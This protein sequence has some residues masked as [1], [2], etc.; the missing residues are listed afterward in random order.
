MRESRLLT[1]PRSTTE[2]TWPTTHGDT[3]TDGTMTWTE[4]GSDVGT[5]VMD[6]TAILTCV[7]RDPVWSHYGHIVEEGQT[8]TTDDSSVVIDTFPLTDL[9]TTRITAKITA[10]LN[11]TPPDGATF[12][13][14]G[15][16]ARSGTQVTTVRYP[17]TESYGNANW[18]ATMVLNGTNV[19]LVVTGE[20]G[21]TIVWK[22]IRTE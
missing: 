1:S 14:N 18:F 6:G 2:P 13:V 10:F 21:K 20:V 7:G 16:W 4:V 17:T 5:Y 3:V 19:N 22:S 8:T 12:E 9:D 11:S 15:A